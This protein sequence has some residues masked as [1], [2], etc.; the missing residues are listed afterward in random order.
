MASQFLSNEQKAPK[1]R[2]GI[3]GATGAVGQRFILLLSE[4]PYLEIAALGASERSAGKSYAEAV[5]WRQLEP[6]PASVAGL[7]VQT[8][9]PEHFK[10]CD[11]I[12][13]GLDTAKAREVE[14]EFAKFYAVFSNA[15]AYRMDPLTPLVVPTVNLSHLSMIPSQRQHLK[16][17]G[18]GFLVT[19]SNCAVI[20]IVIPFAA[21]QAKFGPISDVSVVTLQALS[22]A[23]YPG[24]SSMDII[25]NIVPYIASEESKIETEA[26]KIL[27]TLNSEQNQVVP[28][29]MRVSAA[30][31]RVP[32]LDGHTAC[33]SLRFATRPPPS[34]SAVK[35]ALQ[36]Y[37]SEAQ[38]LG[39][40]SAPAR[41]IVVHEDPTRPQPRLDRNL[42]RGYAV[43]VG[44]VR[45]DESGIFDIKF[46]ALSHNT[47]I[48]AAGS[49]VLNCEAAILKGYI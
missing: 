1:K 12:F 8:C 2:C 31:N 32:V 35:A 45:E 36:S 13:S 21:L 23:G 48:G 46:V 18:K 16:S 24:V 33:V 10:G 3:L 4:H 22:G 29:Q 26:C 47:I 38:T 20:G 43:S 49:S 27:G 25:D 14:P 40:H 41:A 11:I 15:S 37:V 34:V 6:V 28:Q 42:E 7:T 17:E 5:Q 39:C 19:N 44:R 30:C 9:Q